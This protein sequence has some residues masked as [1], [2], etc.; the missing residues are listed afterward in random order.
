MP[1]PLENG[2]QKEVQAQQTQN[3]QEVQQPLTEVRDEEMERIREENQR[4]LEAEKRRETRIGQMR[5]RCQV[6]MPEVVQ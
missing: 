5:K 1:G 4:R 2:L 3:L 6:R